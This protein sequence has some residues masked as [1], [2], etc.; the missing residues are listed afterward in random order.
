LPP[1]GPS[2][3]TRNNDNPSNS[4]GIFT[5]SSYHLGGGVAAMADGS[6]RF[7]TEMIDCG[8]YGVG[9][10]KSFGVWGALGTINGGENVA[11]F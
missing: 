10:N 7:I 3:F 6:V 5:V 2:C 8:N 9:V 11:D 4:T 1:N